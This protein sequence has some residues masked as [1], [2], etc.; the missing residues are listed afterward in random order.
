MIEHLREKASDIDGIGGSEESAL[1]KL[2]VGEGLFDEA[3]TI[4]EAA[5]DFQGGDVLAEGRELL[6]LSF[7]DA[8]GRIEDD[9]ADT[10]DI[11]KS[12]GDSA[13]GVT[14]GGH[15]DGELPRFAADEIAHEASQKT[16]AKIL[17]GESGTVEELEDVKRGG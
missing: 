7:A 6:F 14:R 17:E 2:L 16:S 5:G 8:F 10:G 3:L 15:E 11:E 13:A 12:V 1:V 4:V 9:D